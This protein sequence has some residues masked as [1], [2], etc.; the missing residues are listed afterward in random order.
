[1]LAGEIRRALLGLM[2]DWKKNHSN[3]AYA[4]FSHAG[5]LGLTIECLGLAEFSYAL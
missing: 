2:E 3:H 5:P 4:L 1:M